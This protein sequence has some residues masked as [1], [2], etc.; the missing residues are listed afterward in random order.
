MKHISSCLLLILTLLVSHSALAQAQPVKVAILMFDDVQIIDFAGPFEVFGQAGFEVYTVSADGR[1][2]TTVMGLSVNPSYSFDN[3]PGVDVVLVPGGEVHDVMRRSDV[4]AWLKQRRQDSRYIMSVCTGSHILAEAGLLDNLQATTFHRALD[5]LAEDYPDVEVLRDRRFVDNGQIITT[6]GL[7]SGMDGA[8][9]L[10]STIKGVE[11][12][13]TL[14]MH[15]EYDWDPKQGFVRGTM[16]DRHLPDNDYEWPEGIKFERQASFGDQQSW[17]NRYLA[18]TTRGAADLQATYVKAMAAHK[19]WAPQAAIAEHLS[20]AA[21]IE[22]QPWVH[23]FWVE[24]G[25]KPDTYLLHQQ[26]R[27]VTAQE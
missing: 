4:Q 25:D 23:E 22:G 9:H 17:Q 10:V 16:A 15:I 7:S 24:T 13:R 20:W 11:A 18:K 2:V 12:A 21:T 3:L 5:G 1:P 27:R 8:L 14:A 26:I 19:D 6:A